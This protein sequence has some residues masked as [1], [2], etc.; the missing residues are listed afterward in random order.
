MTERYNIKAGIIFSLTIAGLASFPR[1]LRFDFELI[2]GFAASIVYIFGIT[3]TCW[4]THHFF[5]LKRTGNAFFDNKYI[6]SIA[7]IC[8][9]VVL[10]I[11]ISLPFSGAWS[12]T[13]VAKKEL[14]PSQVLTIRVFR[15]IMISALTYGMV[16]YL[17]MMYILQQAGIE[18]EH[19]KQENL[20]A[21]LASLKEQ[22]SPHFLF[23]SLNT[24][25]TLSAEP[26]VKEYIL[27]MSDV[28]RYVLHY[29]E[30][31][32]A[33]VKD[34]LAFIRS[35][36]YI[37]ETRFEEALKINIHISAANLQRQILPFSLQ[38]LVENALKHNTISYQKPLVIDIYN[39]EEGI[40][41]ENTF[42]P[43]TT[44]EQHSGTG[45]HNLC[46]RY[47]LATGKE[48]TIVHNENRF[49]V[50]IPFLQ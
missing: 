21:Q 32:E 26:V 28:Y 45:L 8:F 17:R 31:H 1:L 18:N 15:L 30:K 10:M 16:Y 37:L 39:D 43:R 27:K 50:K 46:Q 2:S 33:Q 19:L 4:L 41:V 20:K 34:E 25:S 3:F 49:K 24:L 35:Y 29:Q 13:V 7:S 22:I 38:L 48:I 14:T 11:V 44:A 47:K 23:N 42:R 12:F 36:V 40:T 6:K 9:A 5:L